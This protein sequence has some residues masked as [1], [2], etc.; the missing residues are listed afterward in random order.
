MVDKEKKKKIRT[1]GGNAKLRLL[2][3][4]YANVYN[5][6][7]NTYTKVKIESVKENEANKDFVRRNVVTKGAI[8]ETEK[9][10]AKV[11]SRPGQYGVVNAILCE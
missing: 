7:D 2:N 4:E 1:R 5:K 11:T 6:A 8:I 10:L 3:A 9:G